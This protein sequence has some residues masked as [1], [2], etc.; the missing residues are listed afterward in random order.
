MASPNRLSHQRWL[1]HPNMCEYKITINQVTKHDIYPLS[2]MDILFAALAGGKIFSK[3]NLTHTNQQ[4]VFDD[5]SK[6]ICHNENQQKSFPVRKV[7][8]WHLFSPCNQWKVYYK[9]YTESVYIRMT[10]WWQALIKRVIFKTSI[11]FWL[12]FNQQPHIKEMKVHLW[13]IISLMH[14]VSFK[15]D[16]CWLTLIQHYNRISTV[17]KNS[18][19]WNL[20]VMNSK[21]LLRR[22]ELNTHL[23]LLITHRPS[24][25]RLAEHDVQTDIRRKHQGQNFSFTSY[26]PY[27]STSL[28]KT[29]PCWTF[30]G[31][32]RILVHF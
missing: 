24:S 27:H 28:Y 15:L 25:N 13:V 22:M 9:D 2:W 8:I 1:K 23:R 19:F 10:Y 12:D 17:K 5:E 29:I 11:K 31:I 6:K 14:T 32:D 4:L 18:V 7:T 16:G 30:N 26:L 3:L 21:I 20:P